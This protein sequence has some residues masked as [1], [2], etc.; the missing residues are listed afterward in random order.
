MVLKGGI[1]QTLETNRDEND[2]NLLNAIAIPRGAKRQCSGVDD[3]IVGLWKKGRISS[4]EVQIGSASASRPLSAARAD[5]LHRFATIGAPCLET[6]DIIMNSG[7]Q[8]FILE[9]FTPHVFSLY[10]TWWPMVSHRVLKIDVSVLPMLQILVVMIA[11]VPHGVVFEFDKPHV[12]VS[13]PWLS[14]T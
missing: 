5:R 10:P 8:S 2:P 7:S 11:K 1:R 9:G 6:S 3:F 12:F 4:T 14:Q 13:S